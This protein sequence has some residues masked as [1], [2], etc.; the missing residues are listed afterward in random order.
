MKT[1]PIKDA[2]CLFALEVDVVACS[3]R[4]LIKLIATV[5]GVTDAKIG[6]SSSAT[7]RD[8]RATFRFYGDDFAV[9]EPFGDNSRYW[10]GP[11]SEGRKRDISVIESRLA[12]HVP[13]ALRRVLGALTR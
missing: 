1:Y 4:D 12:S 3:V 5:E 11:I 7:D 10:I 6:G 13:T 8:V 2:E 9:V